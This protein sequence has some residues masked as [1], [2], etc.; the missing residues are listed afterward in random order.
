[1]ETFIDILP[2]IFQVLA[3]LGLV[4]WAVGGG[5]LLGGPLVLRMGPAWVGCRF[6]GLGIFL[7]LVATKNF[8][9]PARDFLWGVAGP[10]LAVGTA[11]VKYRFRLGQTDLAEEPEDSQRASR[12]VENSPTAD[13][14]DRD[15]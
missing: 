9:E 3:F 11:R 2:L 14:P 5:G 7:A 13:S 8:D 10:A 1:V 6:L 12:E 4:N 15:G